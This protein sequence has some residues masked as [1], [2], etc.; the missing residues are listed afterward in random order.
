MD[1]IPPVDVNDLKTLWSHVEN[2]KTT[3]GFTDSQFVIGAGA[4][5]AMCPN[6]D[7]DAVSYRLAM[8]RLLAAKSSIPLL[9]YREGNGKLKETVFEVAA[10]IV[11]RRGLPFEV[12][13]F[14]SWLK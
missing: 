10:T 1:M 8:L 9:Q 6:A 2:I 7:I 14:F 13:E 3:M 5:K 12:E 4:M 11:M